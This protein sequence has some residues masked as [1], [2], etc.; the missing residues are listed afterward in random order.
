MKVVKL[1]DDNW[2]KRRRN[3]HRFGKSWW[4]RAHSEGE[5]MPQRDKTYKV[6]SEMRVIDFKGQETNK[7]LGYSLEGF[8][9]SR[10]DLKRKKNNRNIIFRAGYF[11]PERFETVFDEYVPNEILEDGTYCEKK[12][13]IVVFQNADRMMKRYLMKISN[14]I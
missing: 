9:F 3:Y 12:P 13:M 11:K 10:Y 1:I 5:R 2:N 4:Q 6:K 8:D 7:I 14:S